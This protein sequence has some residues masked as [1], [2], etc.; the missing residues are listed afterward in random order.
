MIHHG[1]D[2]VD[3]RLKRLVQRIAQSKL[4]KR[5]AAWKI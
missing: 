3:Q 1:D 5:F 4:A 2:K